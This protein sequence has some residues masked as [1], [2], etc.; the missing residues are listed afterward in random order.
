MIH[1]VAPGCCRKSWPVETEPKNNRDLL[2]RPLLSQGFVL[3]CQTR[4]RNGLKQEN[5]KRKRPRIHQPLRRRQL[6]EL[7]QAQSRAQTLHQ[8]LTQTAE[9]TLPTLAAQG[10]CYMGSCKLQK[11]N[12]VDWLMH[13]QLPPQWI[14]SDERVPQLLVFKF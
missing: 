3:C 11:A 8:R 1:L 7:S 14:E 9:R 6:A 10:K 2:Y 12:K 13:Q 5:G 4:S